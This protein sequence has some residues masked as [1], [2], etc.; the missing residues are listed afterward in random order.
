MKI[1]NYG[2]S[3]FLI[4]TQGHRLLFDPF[5]SPNDMAKNIDIA[6]IKVDYMLVSHAHFDHLYDVES[7]GKQCG[8]KVISNW[9]IIE[10]YKKKG[11][12][13]HPMSHGGK[14]KFDFG[15]VWCTTAVHSSSFEDGSYGGHP[16][17]FII[18]NSE[19]TLYFAGDTALTFD[20]KLFPML[21]PKIDLA[22]LPIGDNFTMDSKAAALAAEFI[23]CDRI[24]GCHYD[25]F[26]FIKI[27]ADQ[28]KSDFSTQGKELTL[29]P[30]GQSMDL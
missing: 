24:I 16:C 30:I 28:A 14:W 20:M 6:A 15:T 26:G 12:E 5:I 4:E 1:T 7:I 2:H 19:G 21:Y 17:G 9:E 8:A 29:L 23:N 18:H 13:G 27:D 22:I 25:T 11:I 3:C 10:W